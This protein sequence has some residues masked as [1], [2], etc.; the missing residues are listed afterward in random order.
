MWEQAAIEDALGEDAASVL[1][2]A[3]RLVLLRV[4]VPRYQRDVLVALAQK[5]ATTVDEIVTRELEDVVCADVIEL[6]ELVPGLDAALA[7]PDAGAAVPK[8]SFGELHH[9][10]SG[11]GDRRGAHSDWFVH[12]W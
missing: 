10:S 2:E 1:P 9:G 12:E 5:H 7:W 8:L 3:I 4:R 11:V 6:A